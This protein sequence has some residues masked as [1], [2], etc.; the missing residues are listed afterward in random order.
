M[1]RALSSACGVWMSDNAVCLPAVVPEREP[2]HTSATVRNS[3]SLVLSC[4][5][6]LSMRCL[7]QCCHS[8]PLWF[9]SCLMRFYPWSFLA[10]LPLRHVVRMTQS[11]SSLAPKNVGIES[12]ISATGMRLQS[13]FPL[14]KRSAATRRCCPGLCGI[15]SHF[16][17]HWRVH[18]IEGPEPGTRPQA[19]SR[20]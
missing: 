4:A 12:R 7:H 1:I 6:G 11:V 2:A 20:T 16:G 5:R 3:P 10:L 8:E 9:R 13:V 17:R 18:T 15:G 19:P 14:C